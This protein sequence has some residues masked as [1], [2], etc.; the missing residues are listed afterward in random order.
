MNQFQQPKI[1][2]VDDDQKFCELLSEELNEEKL[3]TD[4]VFNGIDALV[5]IKQENYNLIIL[6]VNMP[7]MD[8]DEVLFEI[9]KY[10]SSLPVIMLTTESDPSMIVKCIKLGADDYL[11]KPYDYED[12]LDSVIKYFK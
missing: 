1:L 12:I 6:N 7:G 2:I 8:G 10:D 11:P 9:K 5:K 3:I 4:Y